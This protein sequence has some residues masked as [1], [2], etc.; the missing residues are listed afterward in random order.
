MVTYSS[1]VNN[2]YFSEDLEKEITDIIYQELYE[3]KVIDFQQVALKQFSDWL[4]EEIDKAILDE[5]FAEIERDR[6]IVKRI[7]PDRLFE[8]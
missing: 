8:V 2:N 4:A 3:E 1:P 6:E 5:L 7:I